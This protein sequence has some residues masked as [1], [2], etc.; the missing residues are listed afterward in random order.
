MR[1]R[2]DDLTGIATSAAEGSVG[3]LDLAKRPISRP[4]ELIETAPGVVA[5]QHSGGGKANQFFVR[6]FNLD[7]GTD[8]SLKVNGV[9][10]NMPTHGHGQ[11]YAD[12]NFLIPEM[13]DRVRYRKGPYYADV[14]DFSAAGSADMQLRS[15]LDEGMLQVTGGS[16]GYGRVLWA[17]GTKVGNGELLAAVDV[18]N[19]DGPWTREQEYQGYKGLLRYTV[20][21]AQRGHSFT[22]MG[23]DAD[24]LSTDQVPRRAVDSGLI[25]LFDLIDEGPRGNTERFSLQAEIHRGT[26]D[27]FSELSAYLLAYDFGLISNFTYFLDNPELGD[28]FEQVDDRIVFGL[29]GR[30]TQA[31]EW[32][33][34]RVELGYGADVRFDDIENGL[35]RTTDL[36]RTS[37]VRSDR[38]EQLQG[39][40]WTDALVHWGGGLRTRIGLRAD[41]V[42]VDVD[43]DLA[44]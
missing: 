33:E 1:E 25:G 14:G 28:Q 3:R 32:G 7:H 20:G 44:V 2:F 21:D 37:T 18:F 17:N 31:M 36:V 23:Y 42:E 29:E 11:G 13:V 16:Y 26:S 40:V 19:E 38:I 22:L 30:R 35:F 15:S 5:T 4:G 27:S 34:R 8:F 39:G 24:W 43:S 41:A 12:L 10:V 9:P 6:G